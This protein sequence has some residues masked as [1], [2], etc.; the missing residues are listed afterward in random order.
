MADLASDLASDLAPF[1]A[2]LI[3]GQRGAAVHVKG[4]RTVYRVDDG[5]RVWF[6]KGGHGG[7]R[8]AIGVEAAVHADMERAGLP[9]APLL[10][11]GSV[12]ASTWIVTAPAPGL[13]LDMALRSAPDRA[14]QD[15]CL[16]AVAVA[17]RSVHDGGVRWSDLTATH[18][19]VT[20]DGNDV[21]LIDLA[22]A[23]FLSG[24]PT[25]RQ[26][27]HDLAA[28]LCSLPLGA[29][30]RVQRSRLLVGAL[31]L[32][33]DALRKALVDVRKRGRK[34]ALRTR[35]RH[36][37]VE[38][39]DDV[40]K[41]LGVPEGDLFDAL[42]SGRNMTIVRTL[43][44]RENRSFVGQDGTRFFMKAYPAVR[45]GFSPAMHERAA[46]D[47]LA[48]SGIPVCR[49]EAYGEDVTRGSF[50]V[51][52]G[53]AGEPLDDLIRGGVTPAERRALSIGLADIWR[54]LRARGLRHRDA[55]PCHVFTHRLHA[56]GEPPRFELRL[57]DLTR[58]GPAPF[59]RERW[60]V[61][62]ASQLWHGLPRPAISRTDAVRWLRAYFGVPRLN[63]TAK[64]FARSAAAKERR[65]AKRQA[66]KRGPA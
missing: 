17:V 60:F 66:R 64:R 13:P 54:R 5:E 53:C 24:G 3:D 20:A 35:W 25:P 27:A 42:C 31:G 9:V 8:A 48:Q 49:A 30:D 59:P 65:V 33:G 15:R 10:A 29:C 37:Y 34:L 46:I 32:E 6:A 36:A 21:T 40:R 16:R 51:V 55:Y 38:A 28:L 43:P 50:V 22:R 26:R 63:D 58:A 39:S 56:P 45:Q 11:A 1:V 41:A 61:K 12:D 19:F 2:G 23:E 4:D 7:G 57:I 44:D 18:V 14:A 47:T 62:D 52:R